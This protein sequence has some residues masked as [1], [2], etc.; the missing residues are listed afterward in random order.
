MDRDFIR[1]AVLIP[2]I[3]GLV[4]GV[5]LTVVFS[6]RVNGVMPFSEGAQ[7]AVHDRLTVDEESE[8]ASV[9]EAPKNGRVGVTINGREVVK[10]ADYSLLKECISVQS[11]SN[12][13]SG[14]GCRYLKTIS[15]LA[16]E[17]N[18]TLTVE[19]DDGTQQHFYLTEEFE[20]N[21]EQE[22][23]AIAP[24]ANSSLVVYYQNRNGAGLSS[25]YYVIIYEEVA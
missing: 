20:V 12:E 23:L 10:D 5:L 8:A 18:R 6:T 17:Y 15:G 24:L 21:N 2:V 14:T 4:I 3:T 7:L 22:A 19:H 25:D 16:G 11:G 1:K 13:F 9:N